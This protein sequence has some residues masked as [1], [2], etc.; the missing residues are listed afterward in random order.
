MQNDS[1]RQAQEN[2]DTLTRLRQEI[3][4]DRERID[5]KLN[6]MDDSDVIKKWVTR[7]IQESEAK[8]EV[9]LGKTILPIK[10]KLT[11]AF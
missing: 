5:T 10:Q 3:Q 11:R 8:N 2:H 7:Q 6:C 9:L 1:K 4:N